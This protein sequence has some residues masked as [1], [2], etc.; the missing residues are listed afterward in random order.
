MSEQDES[1]RK[2]RVVSFDTPRNIVPNR[3]RSGE[4]KTYGV[5]EKK[6]NTPPGRGRKPP[7]REA[8]LYAGNQTAKSTPI[9]NESARET[10][11]PVET[12]RRR[13]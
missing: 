12:N 2:K 1:R 11:A 10:P 3:L 4:P 13:H 6:L 9:G 7:R 5:S 8:E